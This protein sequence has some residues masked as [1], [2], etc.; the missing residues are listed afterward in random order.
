MQCMS[1][2]SA[3]I[4]IAV[5]A[6]M[7]MGAGN[8]LTEYVDT[9][10]G[11]DEVSV[12][13]IKSTS[14]VMFPAS[15][16]EV[17]TE[18]IE[19]MEIEGVKGLSEI[20]PNFYMPEYGARMTSSIYVRGLG[21][22]IDQPVVAL[23]VDNVPLLN[24]DN[25]DFTFTDLDHIEV[26]RGPQS[27]LYGRNTI[28]G[29][30]NMTTMS[31]MKY[32]GVRARLDYGSGHTWGGALSVYEKVSPTVGI[33]V[34]GAYRSTD[35][36]Y[37]NEYTGNKVDNEKS[38]MGRAKVAW[39]PSA[40]FM[41]ENSAWLTST[42]QGGYPYES[43]ATGQINHNDTCYYERLTVADGLTM[44]YF[45]DNVSVSSI[46]S[47][48]YINDDMTLDQDFL[49][50]DYFTLSQ[51][52]H[53]W[54]MTQDFVVKGHAGNY[55]YIGGLFGF[56]KRG[57]MSAPVTMK[58]YGIKTLIEDKANK[59]GSPMQI[60]WDERSMLLASDFMMPS[61]GFALY[62][63]SEYEYGNWRASVGL[64]LA[65]ERN[66]IDY[67]SYVN[68]GLT[69]YRQQGPVMIPL[70]QIPVELALADRLHQTSLEL[71]PELKLSY[72]I[73]K[74]LAVGVV[75]SKGYKAGGY[76]TQ[77]FSDILQQKLM[78]MMPSAGGA[79]T[80]SAYDVDDVISYDPENNWNYEIDATASLFDNTL[81][82]D[83]AV[84]FID[85]RDQQMTVFPEGETTGRMM[86]NAG[87]TH[88]KG[89]ELSATWRPDRHFVANVSYGLVDARFRRYNNGVVDCKGNHVPYAP[90]NTLFASLTYRTD[91]NNDVI[92]GIEVNANCRGVG[93]VYWDE[94]NSVKQPF[95]AVAG[96]SVNVRTKLV[97]VELWG[98]NLTKTKYSTFYFESIGNKFLQRGTPRRFGVTLRYN[99]AL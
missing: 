3:V 35:G 98:D 39:R 81:D 17:G 4:V 72:S 74:D 23:N 50:E 29:T 6:T 56:Y 49:P 18:E 99:F 51:R 70:K 54:A 41:L 46:T 75:V 59:P 84:F 34:A 26:V 9:V 73:N 32:Q 61:R 97:D 69:L 33:S 64:R 79:P 77:M 87:R 43:V 13:V 63:E 60:K 48:Q 91:F 15:V 40:A 67:N 28:G 94:E 20:A 44:R 52:R 38:W 90:G 71:L 7:E 88:S 96:L 1:K 37:R 45:M 14:A 68:T 55:K 16:T 83:A 24:K 95:Y 58:D 25:Y 78:G 66:E 31:P 86:T 42:K 2:L 8:S 11:L 76:N 89:L 53:E 65:H 5:S 36:F 12:S 93:Q 19:R 27:I 10:V 92:K 47:F 80:T 21:T 82:V 62:H 57:N 22:R 85:T 30:I